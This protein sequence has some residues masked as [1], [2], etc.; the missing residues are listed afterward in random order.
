M[1]RWPFSPLRVEGWDA[2]F[3]RIFYGFAILRGVEVVVDVVT[4]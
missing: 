4:S 3:Y 1:K 2:F